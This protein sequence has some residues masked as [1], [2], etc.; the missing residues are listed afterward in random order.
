MDD[1]YVVT[2]DSVYHVYVEQ[3]APV[4]ENIGNHRPNKS[5]S[6]LGTKLVGEAI[7]P[8]PRGLLVCCRTPIGMMIIATTMAIVGFFHDRKSAIACTM[9]SGL[10]R[11]DGRWTKER[12][13]VLATIDHNN[14]FFPE[15][16]MILLY[17]KDPNKDEYTVH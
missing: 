14:P 17:P 3:N 7:L 13:E 12:K 16:R 2:L 5:T 6:A 9:A 1:F 15:G 4:A 11:F 10:Q 8:T